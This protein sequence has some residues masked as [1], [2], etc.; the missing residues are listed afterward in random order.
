MKK[1]FSITGSLAIAMAYTLPVQAADPQQ[2]EFQAECAVSGLNSK[3]ELAGGKYDDREADDNGRKHIAA[4]VS[5]PISCRFGLQVDVAYGSLGGSEAGG[6]AG[7]FFARDPSAYLLGALVSYSEIADNQIFRVGVEA[8]LYNGQTSFEA[9]V[10]Y[11]SADDIDLTPDGNDNDVFGQ[12]VAAFYPTDD[13]RIHAG[14]RRFLAVD[15]AI[16]GFEWQP[17]NASY[18][19]FAEGQFGDDDFRTVFGGIR[20]YF[21]EEDKSLIRRHREDDPANL[22]LNLLTTVCDVT[23]AIPVVIP[24][25]DGTISI[26]GNDRCGNAIAPPGK[27]D[28]GGGGMVVDIQ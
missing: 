19:L 5:V 21:G 8:E 6:V 24:G 2:N 18:S 25:E 27:K 23:P 22:L 11:E 26:P 14:Y 12:L 7:H 16:V 20:F 3:I 10:G 17:D 28:R 4:S 9:M 1:T 13:F 15:T